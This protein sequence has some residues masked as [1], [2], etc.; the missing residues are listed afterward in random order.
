MSR[1]E[2]KD[3]V[4]LVQLGYKQEFK[5]DFGLLEL[6]G[7][8]YSIQGV[9]PSIASVLVYSIPYGAARWLSWDPLRQLPEA[10]ITEHF[11]FRLQSI[12]IIFHGFWD[13]STL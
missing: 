3:E 13:I 2:A 10:F 1:I 6:F 7:V 12:E 8:A 9:V 4:L 11:T 5:R